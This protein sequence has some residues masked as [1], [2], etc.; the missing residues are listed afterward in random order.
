[1]LGGRFRPSSTAPPQMPQSKS[2]KPRKSR[3]SAKVAPSLLGGI[4]ESIAGNPPGSTEPRSRHPALRARELT[5][6]AALKAAL[7][8]GSF[9]LPPGPLGLVTALPEL[10]TVW[11]IQARMVADIAAAFGQRHQMQREQLAYCLFKNVAC[12]LARD[13]AVRVAERLIIRRVSMSLIG[14]ACIR[15]GVPII[16]AAGAAAYAWFDTMQ[17]AQRALETFEVDR[18]GTRRRK[19]ASETKTKIIPF[20]PRTPRRASTRSRRAPAGRKAPLRRAA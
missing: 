1:M 20:P 17:V 14:R 4:I 19:P 16:G 15:I 3:D 13:V 2:R 10:L 5:K 11:K 12:Q 7:V 9:S 6:A 8:S 18:R